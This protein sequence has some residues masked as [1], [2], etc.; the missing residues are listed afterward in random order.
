MSHDLGTR[1][2]LSSGLGLAV[3][4]RSGWAP[5]KQSV[6]LVHGYP[7]QQDMW[8]R[9]VAHLDLD[10]LHVVTYDVR[11]AGASDAP[12]GREGYRT[13]ALVEDLI[14]VVGATIPDG[15]P[16]H[17]VG[18]DWGSVQL[19]DVIAREGYDARLTGRIASYTSISGPSLDHFAHLSRNLP[20]RR[21]GMLNQAA[22]SWYVYAFH[23]PFLPELLWSA[24]G[25]AASHPKLGRR[26]HWG[27]EVI[28]NARNGLNLYR[29]NVWRRLRAPSTLRT[30]VPVQ[31][32]H[33]TRD[34]FLT[35][36]LLED[37]DTVGENVTTL[38][39]EAGHWAPRTHPA[40]VARL[41]TS[42]LWS[43]APRQT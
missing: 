35:A 11:G 43:H 21:L 2:V 26:T 30:S 16:F 33:P 37:L 9:M 39:L 1:R 34:R 14:A 12:S 22:H 23:V 25:A 5:D 42:H 40:E 27:P 3:R 41:V 4:E 7:D 31:V 15:A 36:T 10:R 6:V 38:K 24:A 19:W 32:V 29:A 18:H 20:G 28:R 13:E 17:L 8:D